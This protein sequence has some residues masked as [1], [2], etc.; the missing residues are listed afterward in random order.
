MTGDV[1][2]RLEALRANPVALR[3]IED[4][5]DQIDKDAARKAY[6]DRYVSNLVCL[7]DDH[8][9][10]PFLLKVREQPRTYGPTEFVPDP[11]ETL[12]A[13]GL[14][15]CAYSSGGLSDLRARTISITAS[16]LDALR[17][18]AAAAGPT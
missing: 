3:K 11:Y 4:L 2:S 17:R 6:R 1:F 14:V 10:F 7:G 18:I 15:F 16:G 9:H 13:N 8:A 12:E 5:L